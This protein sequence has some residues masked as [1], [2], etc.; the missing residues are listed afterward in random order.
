M[1]RYRAI[2]DKHGIAA[3]FDGEELTWIRK[4]R[5]EKPKGQSAMIMRDIDPYKSMI[6]GEMISSRSRHREHL[7]DHNCIEV[8]NEKMVNTKPSTRT[9]RKKILHQQLA[10]LSDRQVKKIVKKTIKERH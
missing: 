4:D 2:F 1:S 6:T 7:R 9:D 3:E 5:I 8:G 10:D